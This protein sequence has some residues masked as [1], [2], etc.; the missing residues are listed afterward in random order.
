VQRLNAETETQIEALRTT[1]Q[2]G[3]EILSELKSASGSRTKDLQSYYYNLTAQLKQSEDETLALQG[4]TSRMVESN[5]AQ[6][7]QEFSR[8]ETDLKDLQTKLSD[9]RDS[10]RDLS[11]QETYASRLNLKPLDSDF[12][13][14]EPPRFAEQPPRLFKKNRVG[15]GAICLAH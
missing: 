15:V 13:P 9:L 10:S 4:Q 8:M 3:H 5:L 6:M 14:V 2:Q 7:R 11:S 12:P 1:L